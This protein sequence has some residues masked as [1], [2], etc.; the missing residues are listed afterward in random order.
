MQL[1]GNWR[2][3]SEMVNGELLV[4]YHKRLITFSSTFGEFLN[5]IGIHINGALNIDVLLLSH[6]GIK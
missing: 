1:A 4:T 5:F 6:N 2:T 3:K